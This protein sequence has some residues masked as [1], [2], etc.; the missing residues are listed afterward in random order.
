MSGD[1]LVRFCERLGVKLPGVTPRTRSGH[2]SLGGE[3]LIF[4][5]PTYRNTR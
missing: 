1:V 3:S 2:S 4:G 5:V